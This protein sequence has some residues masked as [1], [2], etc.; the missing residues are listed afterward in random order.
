MKCLPPWRRASVALVFQMYHPL[1]PRKKPLAQVA[2]RT[3]QSVGGSAHSGLALINHLQDT[4]WGR[5]EVVAWKESHQQ[6][7]QLL[8]LA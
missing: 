4:Q 2:E 1:E 7:R 3:K 6:P 8:N 5:W